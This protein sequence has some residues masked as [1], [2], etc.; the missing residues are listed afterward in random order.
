MEIRNLYEN[1]FRIFFSFFRCT[2]STSTGV[3]FARHPVHKQLGTQFFVSSSP[4]CLAPSPS[5]ARAQSNF[6]RP[7]HRAIIW[8][9]HYT[10]E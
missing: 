10:R 8:R 6:D 1:D 2:Q 3:G 9:V 4:I 7:I 5:Q